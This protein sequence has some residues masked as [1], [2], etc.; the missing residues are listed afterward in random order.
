MAN[1]AG[2]R[3]NRKP[4]NGWHFAGRNARKGG[5]VMG[6]WDFWGEWVGKGSFFEE[7]LKKRSSD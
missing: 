3:V 2:V 6:E 7:M 1:S 4:L 5:M